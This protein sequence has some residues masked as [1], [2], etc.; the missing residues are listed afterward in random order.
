M[1]S[2]FTRISRGIYSKIYYKCSK[3]IQEWISV[4]TY[5]IWTY[6]S[7]WVL[8]KSHDRDCLKVVWDQHC[9]C[10]FSMAEKRILQFPK[11]KTIKL[12]FSKWMKLL[13]WARADVQRGKQWGYC[14]QIECSAII[15]ISTFMEVNMGRP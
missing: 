10:H 9:W 7:R 8:Q 4:L 13:F 2:G 15:C 3:G 12:L 14:F 5:W 11:G 6:L 1:I